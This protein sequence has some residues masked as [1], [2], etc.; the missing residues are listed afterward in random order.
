VRGPGHVSKRIEFVDKVVNNVIVAV[1]AA[2]AATKDTDSGPNPEAERL[3]VEATA[4]RKRQDEAAVQAALGQIPMHVLSNVNAVIEKELATIS[5][6]MIRI[7]EEA[8][9]K[10]PTNDDIL[11]VS[12]DTPE[13]AEWL[14]MHIDDRRDYLRSICN[15]VLL[16]HGKGSTK[17]FN[18]DTV[19]VVVKAPG[20]RRAHSMRRGFSG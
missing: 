12:M 16:P 9:R 19:Q 3:Q 1:R 13:A 5:A 8:A 2:H 20:K 17:V 15:I 11:P 7:E 14:N 4:L 6:A 10:P 18:P